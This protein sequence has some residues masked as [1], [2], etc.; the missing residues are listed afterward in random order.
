MGVKG[1]LCKYVAC[2]CHVHEGKPPRFV[3]FLFMWPRPLVEMVGF[4]ISFP[5]TC[6]RF[7]MD[8]VRAV[9]TYVP[10]SHAYRTWHTYI[11]S[12]NFALFNFINGLEEV[13]PHTKNFNTKHTLVFYSWWGFRQRNEQCAR[14]RS[15]MTFLLKGFKIATLQFRSWLKSKTSSH[16]YRNGMQYSY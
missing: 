16:E 1:D 10:Y 3:V 5:K 15:R 12:F 13:I 8:C 2:Q 14:L 4:I 6:L 9:N 7:F 11:M